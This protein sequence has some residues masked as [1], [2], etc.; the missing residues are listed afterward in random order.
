MNEL[1]LF[2]GG[3]GGL[4]GS[5]LLGWRCVG[6][7]EID[8]YCQKILA[9]RIKDEFLDEAP[10]FGDIKAFLREGYAR[11]YQGVVDVITAG[12][13]CQ[14]WS[15][16]GARRGE[17]D[18]RNLWPD[19]IRVIREVGPRWCMLENVPALLANPYF[20][21]IL[22]DLAE[23][24]YDA[25]W[26]CIPASALGAPHRRDRLWIIAHRQGEQMGIAR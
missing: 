1:A 6:Y 23:S 16:A 10:I 5:K 20:G 2:A 18:D 12:F 3:G 22:S 25:R 13:P 21:R 7:V 4:L 17:R 26:D 15:V 11:S 19:T 24:G 9:Q 8:D 14:P